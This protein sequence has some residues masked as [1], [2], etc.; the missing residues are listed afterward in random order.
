MSEQH[1]P[2]VTADIPASSVPPDSLDAGL[3]AG[4]ARR[5]DAP[6]SAFASTAMRPVLLKEAEGK[7]AAN[8]TF[9]FVP[10]RSR[11]RLS[12]GQFRI[13]RAPRSQPWVSDEQS[14]TRRDYN[15]N[16]GTC[17]RHRECSRSIRAGVGGS[18]S[19][20]DSGEATAEPRAT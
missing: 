4:Y 13:R 6:R 7:S 8:R 16:A 1:D 18:I 9:A 3:A 19:I 20:G 11:P 17:E 14:R 2:D 10:H 5:A 15:P 12:R